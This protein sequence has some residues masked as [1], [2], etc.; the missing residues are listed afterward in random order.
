MDHHIHLFHR[1]MVQM[2]GLDHFQTLIHQGCAVDGD[3]CAHFPVGMLQRI[4]L[5]H[6]SQLFP[7]I[8]EERTAGAGQ[9]D[10]FYLSRAVTAHKALENRRMLR[11]HRHDLRA[12][13]GRLCHHQFTGADQGLL[14]GKTDPLTGPNGRQRRLQA[15]HAHY[16]GDHTLGFFHG[17]CQDQT[18]FTISHFR[19][20]ILDLGRQLLHRSQIRHNRQLGTELTALLCHQFPVGAGGQCHHPDIRHPGNHIQALPANGA[21]GTQNTDIIHHI[22]SPSGSAEASLP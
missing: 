19:I 22:N 21:G 15:Q 7:V 20:Q 6:R 16:C 5:G 9:N 1:Q 4:G 3:L 10:L 13:F 11:I 17:S 12:I 8:A 14:I 18:C 2:H